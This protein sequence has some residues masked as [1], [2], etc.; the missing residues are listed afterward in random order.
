MNSS[1]KL[2]VQWGGGWHRN[3]EKF[4]ETETETERQRGA[5]SKI[6]QEVGQGGAHL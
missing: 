6:A 1:P 4:R 2:H 3:Q 5:G